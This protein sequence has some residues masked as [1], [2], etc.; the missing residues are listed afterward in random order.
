MNKKKI[1]TLFFITISFGLLHFSL[2]AMHEISPV[3]LQFEATYPGSIDRFAR[4]YQIMREAYLL[5]IDKQ[6]N[7]TLQIIRLNAE[8]LGLLQSHPELIA[9][10][11]RTEQRGTLLHTAAEYGCL[12]VVH[13]L[14]DHHANPNI[15]DAELNTPL[16]KAAQ[17]SHYEIYNYLKR[18]GARDD[19]QNAQGATPK[20]I[21]VVMS[22][23]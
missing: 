10:P 18:H 21:S 9:T 17:A 13:Y 4:I 7:T 14:V 5:N 6:K 8:A 23:S 16:H 22:Y 11:L 19:I 3:V 12:P 1:I 2:S 20:A 15:Q